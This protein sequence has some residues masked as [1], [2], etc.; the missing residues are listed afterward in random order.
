RFLLADALTLPFPDAT[1]DVAT[2]AFGI[3]NVE[4]LDAGL[5][6]LARVRR[7]GGGLVVLEFTTPPNPFIRRAFGLYFHRLLP[8]LGNALAGVP[9]NAHRYLPHSVAG[10]PGA[11]EI[12]SAAG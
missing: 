7:P 5:R 9:T 8:R 1:F 12:R 3:R 6:E 11:P 10:V 4:D 2:V